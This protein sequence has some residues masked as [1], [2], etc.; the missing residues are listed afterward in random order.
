MVLKICKNNLETKGFGP[1]SSSC[2]KKVFHL[3]TA[4]DSLLNSVP[5][6]LNFTIFSGLCDCSHGNGLL[7]FYFFNSCFLVVFKYSQYL[8]LFIEEN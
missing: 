1:I 5:Y 8:H 2:L 6:V 3:T 4:R 7:L